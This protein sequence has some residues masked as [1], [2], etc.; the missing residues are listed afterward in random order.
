MKRYDYVDALRG[1][2]ILGVVA[3]HAGMRLPP[4]SPTLLRLM[5]FG[6]RG[7]QLF[8]VASAL[9]LCLS[10]IHR[11][12]REE[13]ALRN[14][15]VRR[16]FRILPLFWVGIAFYQA[17]YGAVPRYWAPNG[18]EWWF[19]PL[20]AAGLHGLH[21]ETINSVVPGGWSIAA[22]MT[23]YLGL[24]FV[25]RRRE[26][27]R[28]KI[29]LLIASALL[30]RLGTPL[31]IDALEP[32]Y[33]AQQHYLLAN[34]GELNFFAQ[35][36]V[37]ALGLLT[38]EVHRLGGVLPRVLGLGGTAAYVCAKLAAPLGSRLDQLLSEHVVVSVALSCFALLLAHWPTALLRNRVVTFLGTISF[39]LYLTH[40]FVLDALSRLGFCTALGTGDFASVAFFA[41]VVGLSSSAS[42]LT[43]VSVERGGI[44]LGKR[45]LNALDRRSADRARHA[46]QVASPPSS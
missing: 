21:P 32:L 9:T 22:E 13:H 36:P 39:S 5:Q 19:L 15:Y 37:F 27:L 45:F 20:T 1:Y 40:F 17:V 41:V 6:A 44:E 25:L 24:P 33:P 16:L 43:Y 42:Y 38:F 12:P 2:A 30:Y 26:P 34:F 3:V 46:G 28:T 23:F 11:A 18:I 14:F 29:G 7:V 8:F 4:S 35:L 31:L 10:W